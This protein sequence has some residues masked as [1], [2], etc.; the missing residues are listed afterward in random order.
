MS[1]NP[2]KAK[3]TR[4]ESDVVRFLRENGFPEAR[5]VSPEGRQDSGDI[6]V[7]DFVAQAKAWRDVAGGV[8]EGVE[9]ARRQRDVAGLDYGVA[10]VKRPRKSTGDGYVVLTLD[11]FARLLR[12]Y[13]GRE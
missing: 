8:R 9:G 2:N 10:I 4:W 13:Y 5:R 1:A 7:L 6:H 11:E 12:A 3:G